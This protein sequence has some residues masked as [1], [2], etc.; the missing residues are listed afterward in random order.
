[1]DGPSTTPTSWSS[2]ELPLKKLL[3]NNR[4]SVSAAISSLLATMTAFPLDSIKSRLQVNKYDSVMDCVKKTYVEEGPKGFYRGIA[5]PMF[6][7]TIVRTLSFTIYNDT[8]HL[9]HQ[10]QMVASSSVRDIA[11]SGLAGGMSS[12]FLISVGSCAFELVKIRSQLE[13]AIAAKQGR[14][15]QDITTWRGAKEIISSHG[16]K[17]LYFGF[18]LHCLR[19]TLGTGIYFL[20]YDTA[21]FFSEKKIDEIEYRRSLDPDSDHGFLLPRSALP[22]L[23]G[24]TCGVTSWFII[25]PLDVVKSRLQRDALASSIVVSDSTSSQQNSMNNRQQQIRSTST[26]KNSFGFRAAFELFKQLISKSNG[27]GIRVLYSGLS[28]SAFR[29][30]FQH[31]VMWTILERVRNQ[32]QVSCET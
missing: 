26:P 32:I 3:Y 20:G 16:L 13:S 5:I 30:F 29:S 7:I 24:S 23:C 15:L 27:G 22:F 18:N 25:Y 6:T 14:P 10:R 21:R 8:K 1:M 11:L 28:I 2:L 9:L 31:G 17:G 12:G 19:D 4:T